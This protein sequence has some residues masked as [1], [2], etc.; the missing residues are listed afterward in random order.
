MRNFVTL[1]GC[2]ACDLT[3]CSYL[4]VFAAWCEVL[5]RLGV[6][7]LIRILQSED[8]KRYRIHLEAALPESRTLHQ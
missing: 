5:W 2:L 6:R 3:L 1:S 8:A 4:C 7:L